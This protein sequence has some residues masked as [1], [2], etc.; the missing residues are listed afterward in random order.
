[1]LPKAAWPLIGNQVVLTSAVEATSP[2]CSLLTYPGLLGCIFAVI[3]IIF[4]SNTPNDNRWIS[5]AEKAYLNDEM[6]HLTAYQK[7]HRKVPWVSLLTASCM[8]AN[9]LCQFSYNFLQTILQ[10][11]LPTYFKDALLVDLRRNGI[12]TALPSLSQLIFKNVLG[13]L[14][15]RLKQANLIR[16]TAACK[17]FQ[18]VSSFGAAIT[19]ISLALFVDCT[20]P[21]LAVILLILIAFCMSAITPGFFTSLLSIAPQFTGIISSCSM[22]FGTLGNI[23][24]PNL[25]G[26]FILKTGA[27]EEWK[28]VFYV[29]AG[30]CV[31]TGCVFMIFGSGEE[32]KWAKHVVTPTV[33]KQPKD[34]TT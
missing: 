18:A 8:I 29:S 31:F 34:I 19:L 7:S 26:G 22:V 32:Q 20:N 33:E 11:Y 2:P 13:V 1:M 28:L 6:S 14:S 4:A 15:D 21:S 12:Y 5:K 25:I 10:S 9:L 3:W 23:A 17:L 24:A 27:L 16:P 30:I